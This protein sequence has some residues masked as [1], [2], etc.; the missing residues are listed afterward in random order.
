MSNDISGSSSDARL[1]TVGRPAGFVGVLFLLL[2]VEFFYVLSAVDSERIDAILREETRTV[3][4]ARYAGDAQGVV[5]LATRAAEAPVDA[6]RFFFSFGASNY[7]AKGVEPAGEGAQSALRDN[8]AVESFFARHAQ[9]PLILDAAA[10]LRLAQNRMG[11]FAAAFFFLF[12]LI[13]AAVAD[14]RAARRRAEMRGMPPNPPMLARAERFLALIVALV[15]G[16]TLVPAVFTDPFFWLF[17]VPTLFGALALR[18]IV[19]HRSTG[20]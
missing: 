11:Q 1:D 5:R 6:V 18:T 8:A 15:H 4:Y 17:P 13:P 10:L 2:L 19:R 7:R 9:D 12:P 20:R 3:V 14:G 16:A